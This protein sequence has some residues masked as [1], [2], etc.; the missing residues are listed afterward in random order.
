M[1]YVAI[2]HGIVQ[3]S[4][5]YVCVRIHTRDRLVDDPVTHGGELRAVPADAEAIVPFIRHPEVTG[6]RK[7]Y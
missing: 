3:T 4:I 5:L 2:L 1:N 7:W 6:T